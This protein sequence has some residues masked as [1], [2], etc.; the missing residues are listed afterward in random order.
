VGGRRVK[1]R[2]GLR[3]VDGS[4]REGLTRRQAEAELRRLMA[5]TPTAVARE[6]RRTVAEAGEAYV[7]HLEGVMQR[8]RTTIQDYRGYLSRHLAP[9]FG[10]RTI[11]SVELP[12][13]ADGP[14][15]PQPPDR[16]GRRQRHVGR[17]AL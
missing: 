13:A 6:T 3:R 2:I 16:P 5:E 12:A 10:K 8:K 14:Q 4:G 11:D 17:R 9:H 15:V 7:A 1:R